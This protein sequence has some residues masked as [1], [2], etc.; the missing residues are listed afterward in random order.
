MHRSKGENSMKNRWKVS[1]VVI[2][3]LTGVL[4][5]G[6]GGTPLIIPPSRGEGERLK[7]ISYMKYATA[8]EHVVFRYVPSLRAGKSTNLRVGVEKFADK[9][10][11]KD[12]LTTRNIADVDEK[13][14][15]RLL[16]D[17]Q[18]WQIFSA[19]DFPLQKDKDDLIMSGE[20]RRFYWKFSESPIKFIPLINLLILF[21][22]PMYYVDGIIELQVRLVSFK[23]GEIVAEYDKRSAKKITLNLYTRDNID[24]PGVELGEAFSDVSEQ[25]KEAIVSDIK[26]GRL[27]MP[28]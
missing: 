2:L 22:I 17:F 3:C 4:L 28:Q 21:G 14:T 24:D 10:P 16:E 11:E 19:I 18:A 1:P 13:V 20:I 5:Q 9:R 12:R 27:K 8:L 6:C 23:T 7:Q 25:I 26:E 15:G